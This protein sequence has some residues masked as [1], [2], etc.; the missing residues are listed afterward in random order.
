[1]LN[2]GRRAALAARRNRRSADYD[3]LMAEAERWE[4]GVEGLTFLPYLAGE[5]TPHADPD[6]RGAFA[7]LSLR[8]D[9]GALARA[10]LEG[11]AFGLRDSLDLLRELGVDAQRR[12][13]LRRRRGERPVPARG[14]ERARAAGR[15][16]RGRRG[17]RLRRR[18]AGGGRG[19]RVRVGRG[20]RGAGA[21]DCDD[22]AG[23]GLERAAGALPRAVPGA[24]LIRRP[25]ARARRPPQHE[26]EAGER[27]AGASTIQTQS[28]PENGDVESVADGVDSRALPGPP[29]Q[30][31]AGAPAAPLRAAAGRAAAGAGRAAAAG[32]RGG[33]DPPAALAPCRRSPACRRCPSPASTSPARRPGT[34]PASWTGRG[35]SRALRGRT[36][37]RGRGGRSVCSWERL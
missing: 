19:G 23:M 6:A 22:R 4:P 36:M 34:A 33:A 11:V 13:R 14:G 3:E 26:P 32:A 10:V 37:R 30:V 9:R 29:T 2:A 20:S 7:G 15:A 5:R 25:R 18:A 24:A 17:R 31:R 28:P 35:S 16:H 27:G 21:P 1:M 8:H 12:P